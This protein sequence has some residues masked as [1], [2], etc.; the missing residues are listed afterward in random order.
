[1][2][3]RSLYYVQSPICFILTPVLYL[4][5]PPTGQ[6]K[7]SKPESFRKRLTR[8]DYWGILTMVRYS[9]RLDGLMSMLIHAQT[10]ANVLLLYSLSRP[11]ISYT[12]IAI[13]LVLFVIFLAVES[14]PAIAPEPIVPISI[15]RSRG[16]LLSGISSTGI[17]M[18]RWAILFYLPVYGIAV[19]GWS[20]AEGGVIM[21]PTNAGFALGGLLV[22]WIHIRKATSYYTYDSYF[23]LL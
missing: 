19:R 2:R 9:M 7:E 16:V 22:G 12:Y 8:I 14:T 4:A 6:D 3:Q 18:A 13:S 17:M 15:V 11:N 1:M 10:A 5:I 23:P 20:P 21:I